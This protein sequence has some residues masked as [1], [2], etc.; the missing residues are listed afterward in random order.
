M[1]IQNIIIH[2]VRRIKD[3]DPLIVNYKSEE[4]DLSTLEDELKTTC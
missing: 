3:G 2:E 1:G 4:N